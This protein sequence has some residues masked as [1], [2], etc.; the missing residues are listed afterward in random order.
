MFFASDNTSGAHPSI[1]QAVVAANDGYQTSYGDDPLMDEVRERLRLLFDAPDAVVHLVATGTAA[2]SLILGT[3]A[4][5]YDAIFC[6]PMAHINEDEANAPEF[7]TGGAKLTLVPT[8]AAKMTPDALRRCIE[9]EG[10]RGVHGPRRGPVSVTNVTEK[11]TVYS[12]E[13]LSAI[14]G[15][16]GT[17]GLHLH[18]DGA[19]FANAAVALGCSAAEMARDVDAISFGGSKNGCLGVEAVVI[20]DGGKALEFEYRRKRG[21]HLFSKHRYLSAQM[22]AYLRDDLW[23]DLARAANA[24]TTR[25]VRGLRHMPE[26]RFIEEPQANMVFAEWPRGLHQ[27]LK[28]AGARYYLYSGA[29]DG[30]QDEMQIARLVTSWSTTEADVDRFLEVMRAR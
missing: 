1:L 28:A 19:R 24:A 30:P 9:A 16:C 25:L 22:A 14:K 26:V 5:P 18:L 11:G 10:T 3:L 8:E 23:L 20:R 21:G 27:R 29:E 15:I 13:E 4:Q 2:N 17:F 12:T 7:Y 6:T